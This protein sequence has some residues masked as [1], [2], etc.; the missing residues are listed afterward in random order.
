ME[1]IEKTLVIGISSIS[2]GNQYEQLRYSMG[3]VA[4][5]VPHLHIVLD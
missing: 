2:G 3:V 1:S 5:W 4:N